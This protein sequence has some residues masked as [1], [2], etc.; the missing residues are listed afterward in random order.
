MDMVV[1]TISNHPGLLPRQAWCGIFFVHESEIPADWIIEF[2]QPERFDRLKNRGLPCILRHRS[3]RFRSQ[4]RSF[5]RIEY[6]GKGK[7][8]AC[9]FMTEILLRKI[10]Q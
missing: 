4:W 3:H 1:T 2:E 8:Q 9:Q 6:A 7:F 5:T 10:V